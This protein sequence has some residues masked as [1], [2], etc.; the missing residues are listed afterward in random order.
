MFSINTALGGQNDP[1]NQGQEHWLLLQ[2]ETIKLFN[3]E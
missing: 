3:K 1:A 2:D